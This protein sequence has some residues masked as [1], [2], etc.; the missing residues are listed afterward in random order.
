M[1]FRSK[2]GKGQIL[3]SIGYR[4]DS[5]ESSGKTE[6]SD[7]SIG[8]GYNRF[9]SKYSPEIQPYLTTGLEYR[10]G[11]QSG[12]SESSNSGVFYHV[13]VGI[14][15]ALGRS[16]FFNLESLF[17]ENALISTT[18]TGDEESSVTTIGVN[19]EGD[20]SSLKVGLGMIL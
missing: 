4:S 17:F 10:M 8:I 15:F 18:K 20:L 6:N 9:Y 2:K 3:A 7:T 1:L 11:S 14:R 19:S 16:F 12:V 5:T 13:G